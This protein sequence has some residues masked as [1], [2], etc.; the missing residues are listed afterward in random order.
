M[1]YPLSCGAIQLKL[2]M[3]PY[4]TFLVLLLFFSRDR[5]NKDDRPNCKS[6]YV[7]FDGF[8]SSNISVSS[9]VA[10]YS[11]FSIEN[12]SGAVVFEHILVEGERL[13]DIDTVHAPYPDASSTAY[14]KEKLDSLRQL[15]TLF[16]LD[17]RNQRGQ[18]YYDPSEWTLYLYVEMKSN[19]TK[20]D[21]GKAVAPIN[22]KEEAWMAADH[23]FEKSLVWYGE[24]FG[25]HVTKVD[26]GYRVAGGYVIGQCDDLHI[27][28]FEALVN[29]DGTVT[30]IKD[31]GEVLR[32]SCKCQEPP[33]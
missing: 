32:E 11:I 15:G 31:H 2:N 16:T 6:T 8:N 24:D 7:H 29:T 19:G 33:Q 22:T 20:P 3:K 4:L 30:T 13:I 14:Y 25:Q 9:Q 27:G 28:L 17:H 21:F 12:G 10:K 23:Q 18:G 1:Q 26:T 5:L